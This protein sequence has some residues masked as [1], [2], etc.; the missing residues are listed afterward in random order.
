MMLVPAGNPVD[1]VIESLLPYVEEGDVVIDGGN[2]HYTDTLRRV[3]YLRPK[4]IHFMG[5]GISG[6]EHGAR[7]QRS[8]RG[9]GRDPYLG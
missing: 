3:A 6:G 4:G 1:N 2:S 9:R 8:R 7:A 5:M